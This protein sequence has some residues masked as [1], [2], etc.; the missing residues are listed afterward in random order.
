MFEKLEI[1]L[2]SYLSGDLSYLYIHIYQ[3]YSGEING[4]DPMIKA[5]G[6][7]VKLQ[8]QPVVSVWGGKASAWQPGVLITGLP[9]QQE[10]V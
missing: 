5:A 1:Q 4:T 7:M 8:K 3:T 10:A 2:L 6:F 9:G